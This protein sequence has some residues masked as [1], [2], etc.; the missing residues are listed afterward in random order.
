[1]IRE[2]EKDDYDNFEP[3]EFSSIAKLY[4][5]IGRRTFQKYSLVRDNVVKAIIFFVEVEPDDWAGFFLISKDFTAQDGE[6]IRQFIINTVE[7]YQ[8]KRLWTVSLDHKL[9]NRWHRFLGLKIEEKDIELC[10]KKYIRWS[11]LTN[12]EAQKEV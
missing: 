9:I 11:L 5:I 12:N 7:Q 4:R 3:N 2:F 6:D 1:M 8:A 10:G